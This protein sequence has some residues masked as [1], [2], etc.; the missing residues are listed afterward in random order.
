[1][2]E[3]RNRLNENR[4]ARKRKYLIGIIAVAA[5][6][7]FAVLFEKNINSK[8]QDI[9]IM[10]SEISDEKAIFI[11]VKQLDTN[12]IAV[13]VNDGSY[14]LAFDDCT[15]CYLQFGKHG[16]FENN[17][18]NTGLICKNCE[19]EVM[20]EEMGFLPEESMPYP[21]IESE[22]SS[23][24]DRFVLGADYLEAKKLTIEDM[25]KGKVANDYSENPN[26]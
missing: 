17:S 12:I 13:K 3:I 7:L 24:E 11:P 21:I 6:I 1:M 26:K 16:S 23:L 20:Y 9:T 25:R 22:I 15:G 2:D 10:K 18:D 5:L 4:K 19:S 8:L 14:R